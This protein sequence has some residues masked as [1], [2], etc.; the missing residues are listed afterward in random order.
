MKSTGL[1]DFFGVLM[2]FLGSGKQH[3]KHRNSSKLEVSCRFV[4]VELRTDRSK[5]C[6]CVLGQTRSGEC[7]LLLCSWK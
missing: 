3:H 4:I 7:K 6:I 5:A 1:W 2:F